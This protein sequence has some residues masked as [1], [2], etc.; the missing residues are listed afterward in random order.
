MP[1]P[2]GRLQRIFEVLE[3]F[4]VSI[5]D[6]CRVG[7]PARFNMPFEAGLAFGVQRYRAA[8]H[9]VIVLDTVAFRPQRTLSD[10]PNID[11]SIIYPRGSAAR[12]A[13]GLL[14]ALGTTG[15]EPRAGEVEQLRQRLRRSVPEIKRRLGAADLYGRRAFTALVEAASTAAIDLG[16]L[17]LVGAR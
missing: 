14:D 8:D 16:I 11:H 2:W 1:S 4:R 10:L 3:G 9:E 5:H 15:T 13:S 7:R 12:L 6:L 17:P